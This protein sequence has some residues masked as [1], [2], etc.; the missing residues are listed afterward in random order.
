MV[1]T[2]GL[3][4]IP[5]PVKFA[6][7]QIVRNAQSTPALN[8]KA[9]SL[10]EWCMQYFSDTLLDQTVS[11]DAGAVRGAE[12]WLNMT[13]NGI[14]GAAVVRAADSMLHALGGDRDQRVCFLH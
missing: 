1:Y 12:G 13:D 14:S 11:F 7:A 2:A 6:C 5:D 3:G 9:V 10:I 4:V 8:V